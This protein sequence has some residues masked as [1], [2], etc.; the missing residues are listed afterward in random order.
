MTT[1]IDQNLKQEIVVN[2][3]FIFIRILLTYKMQIIRFNRLMRSQAIPIKRSLRDQRK[4]A[5]EGVNNA[6]WDIQGIEELDWDF[7]EDL[8]K[9][10]KFNR[11]KLSDDAKLLANDWLS[12]FVSNFGFDPLNMVPIFHGKTKKILKD[13]FREN[14]IYL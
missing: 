5:I 12:K 10:Y 11:L 13:F 3:H 14:A 1:E 6:M 2:I 8:I 4:K 9:K 7:I